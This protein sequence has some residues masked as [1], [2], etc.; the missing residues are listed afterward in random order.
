M[1]LVPAA[2]QHAEAAL[3]SD[4]F[5]QRRFAGAVV[6]DE[7]RDRPVEGQL[8]PPARQDRR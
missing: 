4:R 7:E 3:A 5:Q 6:A 2:A 8:Q 1:C